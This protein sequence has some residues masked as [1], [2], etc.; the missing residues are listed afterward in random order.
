MRNNDKLYKDTSSAW[1]WLFTIAGCFVLLFLLPL[2]AFHIPIRDK[3]DA[4]DIWS[5]RRENQ[6]YILAMVLIGL[7]FGFKW[8][9]KRF[10]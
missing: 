2:L 4:I 5:G 10:N 8:L 6:G 9:L 1:G 3:V 7:F